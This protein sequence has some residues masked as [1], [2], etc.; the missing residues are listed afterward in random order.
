MLSSLN[1][2]IHGLLDSGSAAGIGDGCR[3]LTES[4]GFLVRISFLECG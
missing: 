3:C 2:K 4:F 1:S